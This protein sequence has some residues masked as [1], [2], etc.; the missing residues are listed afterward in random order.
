MSTKD[1][2]VAY[3]VVHNIKNGSEMNPDLD[4]LKHTREIK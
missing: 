3:K 1:Q 4:P 2:M